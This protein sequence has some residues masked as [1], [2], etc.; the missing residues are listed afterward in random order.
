MHIQN[1]YLK[2]YL[3]IF[4]LF[5]LSF[6]S[7]FGQGG[8]LTPFD[9]K[10]AYLERRA[11]F[12]R[13][14]TKEFNPS[15]K[16]ELEGMVKRLELNAPNSYEYHFVKYIHAN[17]SGPGMESLLRAYELKPDE[18][19]VKIALFGYY[20]LTNQ[21][22]KSKAFAAAVLNRISPLQRKYYQ[23]VLRFTNQK[24]LVM[25]GEDDA[26]VALALIRSG[27]V[28]QNVQ[29]INLDFLVNDKYK[30]QILQ[31]MGLPSVPFKGNE[32]NF[33]ATVLKSNKEKI[34]VST[35]VSQKYLSKMA[36][37]I[38]ITGLSYQYNASGQLEIL[39]HFWSENQNY[40]EKIQ[41]SSKQDKRLYQNYLPPLLTLYKIELLNGNEHKKLKKAIV[42]FAE[43]VGK[44][45][46]VEEVLKAYEQ[47]E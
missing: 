7:V 32:S 35:T 20:E 19:E 45:S 1:K 14:G 30:N 17:Y 3:V 41:L 31:Q 46:A 8:S 38:F 44:L 25:S 22:S 26:L 39:Q 33:L 10:E 36:E 6:N 34:A 40:L 2:V 16:A 5:V 24:Y 47:I 15:Q 29:I 28:N 12:E 4:G 13:D 9:L 27:Q 18:K 42:L 11:Y 43:K 21:A 23:D 37:H